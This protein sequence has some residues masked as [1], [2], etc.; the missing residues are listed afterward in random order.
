MLLAR[1]A[2]FQ[3][4]GL[5]QINGP[6]EFSQGLHRADVRSR[7]APGLTSDVLRNLTASELCLAITLALSK[8][9]KFSDCL[10]ES[11]AKQILSERL[12]DEN[13]LRETLGRPVREIVVAD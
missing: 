10:P 6:L 3:G 2:P 12:K 7:A 11:E 1:A 13:G 5:Q 8:A 4:A 9:L